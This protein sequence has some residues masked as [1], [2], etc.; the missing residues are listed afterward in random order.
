MPQVFSSHNTPGQKVLFC[1]PTSLKSVW[2]W[3]APYSYVRTLQSW[4]VLQP[5][6]KLYT[7][8][9]VRSF[10]FFLYNVSC[11]DTWTG[12]GLS[13]LIKFWSFYSLPTCIHALICW[14]WVLASTALHTFAVFTSLINSEITKFIG[15][16]FLLNISPSHLTRKTFYTPTHACNP[17]PHPYHFKFIPLSLT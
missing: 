12:L 3:Y 6:I 14:H 2:H 4:I 15:T 10:F 11:L 1:S 16:S 5:C 13:Q 17:L 8:Q 7:V 9:L